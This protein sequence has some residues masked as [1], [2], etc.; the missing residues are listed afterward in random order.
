MR[1][2]ARRE[3][4]PC[5][6]GT[7][8]VALRAEGFSVLTFWFF[9]VKT[10]ELTSAAMSGQNISLNEPMSLHFLNII[11]SKPYHHH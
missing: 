11:L 7:R 8:S 2:N 5:H 6:T 9:C 10:K 4:G 3:I 1:A